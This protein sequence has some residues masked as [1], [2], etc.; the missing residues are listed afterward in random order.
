MTHTGTD[1]AHTGSDPAANQHPLSP[2]HRQAA[3]RHAW[4]A[5][6]KQTAAHDTDTAMTL[7]VVL[8]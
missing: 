7:H 8:V 5:E 4:D 6:F 1:V 2:P 3:L